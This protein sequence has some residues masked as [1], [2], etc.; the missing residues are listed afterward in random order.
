MLADAG[1]LAQI[2]VNLISNA[3]KYSPSGGP[4][5]VAA[6]PVEDMVRLSVIDEGLGIP[7]EE[8]PR[9]FGQFHRAELPDRQGISGSGLGLYIT[10]QLVELHGGRIWAESPGLGHGSA[11]HVELPAA[12]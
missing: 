12:A 1:K 8:L 7:A 10:K 4:V 11:F 5:T 2:L 9:L 6:E 3:V